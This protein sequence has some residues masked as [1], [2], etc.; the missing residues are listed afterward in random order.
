MTSTDQ[1]GS[2]P[3]GSMSRSELFSR[4]VCLVAIGVIWILT[5]FGIVIVGLA[6]ATSP[7]GQ[8]NVLA[9][10]CIAPVVVST[11]LGFGVLSNGV[12]RWLLSLFGLEP[13]QQAVRM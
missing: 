2:T 6:I 5:V 4:A 13:I 8:L 7:V 9:M 1:T 11:C 12:H 3:H 10:L